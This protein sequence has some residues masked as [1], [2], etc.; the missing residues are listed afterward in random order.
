MVAVGTNS[1]S[2]NPRM[3]VVTANPIDANARPISAQNG[4]AMII[5][6]EPTRPS[7]HITARKPIA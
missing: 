5:H 3:K 7:A 1:K 6:G 2:L 4:S